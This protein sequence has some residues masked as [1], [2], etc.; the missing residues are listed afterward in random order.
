MGDPLKIGDWVCFTKESDLPMQLIGIEEKQA[1][2]SWVDLRHKYHAM[3][4]PLTFLKRAE[5]RGQSEE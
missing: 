2:V 1:L 5:P 4:V 3:E